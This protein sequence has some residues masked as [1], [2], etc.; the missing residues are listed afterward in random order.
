MI[1][2]QN[3]KNGTAYSGQGKPEHFD[4]EKSLIASQKKWAGNGGH[5]MLLTGMRGQVFSWS[6]FNNDGSNNVCVIGQPG[7]G[8]GL[9]I[10][11]MIGSSLRCGG[12]AFVFDYS[13][14]Y[15]HMCLSLGGSLLSFNMDANL[16]INPFSTIHDGM[17]EDDLDS[18]FDNLTNSLIGVSDTYNTFEHARL[19]WA[20]KKTWDKYKRKTTISRV[21]ETLFAEGEGNGFDRQLGIRLYP[22]IKD[23]PYG[24]FFEG[25]NNLDL[26]NPF[27]VFDLAGLTQYQH[28]QFCVV[29]ILLT[30][31]YNK[32]ISGDI[33]TPF[34][35]TLPDTKSVFREP[36][37]LSLLE[38]FARK[39]CAY[40]GSLVIGTRCAS[41]FLSSR[42]SK[43]LFDHSDWL[44]LLN[45][46]EKSLNALKI[47]GCLGDM[48]EDEVAFI[49]SLGL[50]RKNRCKIFI[51]SCMGSGVAKLRL[52]DFSSSLY[53]NQ[54]RDLSEAEEKVDK[55]FGVETAVESV[56]KDRGGIV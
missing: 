27:V 48:D 24:R 40:Q 34:Y 46:S 9:F 55:G 25:D 8:S 18:C 50:S 41:D 4:E 44:C 10:K 51:K 23:G 19:S 6:P 35:I 29:N 47:L 20:I 45:Q 30:Q 54:S 32:M 37:T 16:C 2:N 5:G 12:K 43:T 36:F 39:S 13:G 38:M 7:S 42:G 11:D 15:R 31:I 17:D 3:N 21:V 49:N 1:I 28:M 52:D 14:E 22:Y 56:L 33:T 26:S 53:S